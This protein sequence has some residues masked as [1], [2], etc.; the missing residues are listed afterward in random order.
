MFDN[1]AYGEV[2]GYAQDGLANPTYDQIQNPLHQEDNSAM[3]NPIYEEIPM[4]RVK[5]QMAPHNNNIIE[6]IH[7]HHFVVPHMHPAGDQLNNE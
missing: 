7:A 6:F 5:H 3:A 1:P 4:V 2:P